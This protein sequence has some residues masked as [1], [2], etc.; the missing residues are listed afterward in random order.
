MPLF[1]P[2]LANLKFQDTGG[3]LLCTSN[4][5]GKAPKGGSDLE[6]S[7]FSVSANPVIH[8]Y[9]DNWY[10][11]SAIWIKRVLKHR[12]VFEDLAGEVAE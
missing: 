3:L 4:V 1:S 6:L 10:L 11:D 5:F 12:E 9:D 8:V 7:L 2:G